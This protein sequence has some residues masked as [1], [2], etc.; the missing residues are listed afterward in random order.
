MSALTLD[1]K[2]FGFFCFYIGSFLVT[3]KGIEKFAENLKGLGSLQILHLNLK[4]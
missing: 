4:E 3:D 1:R 2:H